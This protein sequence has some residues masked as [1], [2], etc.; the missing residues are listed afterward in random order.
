MAYTYRLQVQ[1]KTFVPEIGHSY[2]DAQY[3]EVS[4]GT[5]IDDFIR[6]NEQKI[7]DEE[8]RRIANWVDAIKNPPVQ[9]EPT[10]EQLVA[11]KVALEEQI[12]QLT[13]RKSEVA[14]SIMTLEAYKVDKGMIDGKIV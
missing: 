7:K 13:A 9:A 14:D 5:N 2:N 4:A 8:A 3:F 6:D 10:E 12:A 1:T 11:E